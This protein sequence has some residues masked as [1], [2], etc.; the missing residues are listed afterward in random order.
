[1][2][3]PLLDFDSFCLLPSPEDHDI[4]CDSIMMQWQY[5]DGLVRRT[6]LLQLRAILI[7][8]KYSMWLQEF[9]SCRCRYIIYLHFV[10]YFISTQILC[11][12]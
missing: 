10:P 9:W 5:A 1:M 4:W 6:C 8:T 11:D 7:G 3:L 2:V 12:K